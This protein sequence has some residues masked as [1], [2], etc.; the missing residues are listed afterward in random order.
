VGDTRAI[1]DP[2]IGESAK[3]LIPSGPYSASIAS[4][5]HSIR[6]IRR[7]A[8]ML[9]RSLRFNAS[10]LRNGDGLVVYPSIQGGRGEEGEGG[11]KREEA[12]EDRDSCREARG[13]RRGERV[14]F[15]PQDKSS[16]A[17]R[18]ERTRGCDRV[19]YKLNAAVASL[20]SRLNR[21][22]MR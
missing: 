4:I 22:A 18:G 11:G 5:W 10:R 9:S 7:S 12:T 15:S 1:Y 21:Y 6:G 8:C 13:E 16:V 14:V 17:R 20:L 3:Y 2:R 19:A